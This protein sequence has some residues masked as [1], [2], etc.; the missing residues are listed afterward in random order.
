VVCSERHERSINPEYSR[1]RIYKDEHTG[2][3]VPSVCRQ[4]K[5]APCAAVCPEDAIRYNE[6][7]GAWVVN[8]KTCTGC[9]LCVDACDDAAIHL[10]PQRNKAFKCDHCG[11]RPECVRVCELGA[12]KWVET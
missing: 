5:D 9:G 7:S 12:L 11:G 6:R 2:R 3:D 8:E 10:H 1:I 4:Y